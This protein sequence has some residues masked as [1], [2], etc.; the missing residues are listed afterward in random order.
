VPSVRLDGDATVNGDGELVGWI[1]YDRNRRSL[2]SISNIEIA[3]RFQGRGYG[4]AAVRAVE[5]LMRSQGTRRVQAYHVL[6]TSVGFWSALGYERA[7]G[8][9]EDGYSAWFKDL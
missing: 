7:G 6:P 9:D 4:R 2:R 8:Y 3:E 5:R 1:S